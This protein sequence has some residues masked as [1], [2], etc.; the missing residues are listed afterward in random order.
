MLSFFEWL[1][2]TPWSIALLESLYVWPLLESTHVLSLALFVGTAIMMDLR[3]LG[4]SFRSVPATA[5][6]GRLLPWNHI[7]FAVMVITGLALFY[8]SP[9]R[10]YYNI[11]FRAKMLLLI[12]AGLNVWLFHSRIHRLVGD[13]DTDPVP[14][15][16]ARFAAAV[17][18]MAWAG[19]VVTG[20]MIAYNWF[21]CDLQPQPAFVNWAAD[22]VIP[23]R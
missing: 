2:T 11:F 18:I 13:W 21:D 23:E 6:T 5:F 20:R 22:C 4:I 16:A 1:E 19:V 3:L 17:S 10:Y 14:P 8:A 15:R 7:G 9:I 12:L